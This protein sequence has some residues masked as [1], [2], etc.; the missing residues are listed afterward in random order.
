MPSSPVLRSGVLQTSFEAV[1]LENI[2]IGHLLIDRVDDVTVLFV[3]T[4]NGLELRKYSLIVNQLCLLERMEL[5][6]P[7]VPDEQW[8]VN[9]AEFISER[10]GP[11]MSLCVT[12]DLPRLEGTRSH[13]DGVGDETL[14]RPLR[15]FVDERP[16][17]RCHG[18]VLYMEW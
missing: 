8:K 14:G 7:N 1:A 2:R 12:I 17:S 4:L 16:V 11:F 15:S 3:V 5:K 10:V 13:H 6:P 18:S 9:H